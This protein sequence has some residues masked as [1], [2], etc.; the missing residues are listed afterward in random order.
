MSP[1]GAVNLNQKPLRPTYLT[2]AS[3]DIED[4][5]EEAT[6]DT[7]VAETA[8][9]LCDEPDVIETVIATED[10][11]L[12]EAVEEAFE[13][14]EEI[15]IEEAEELPEVLPVIEEIE[16]AEEILGKSILF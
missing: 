13:E 10:P 3:D 2:Q 8:C 5:L 14:V 11:V 6:E 12:I 1:V 15:V 16:E 4:L 7:D 9:A